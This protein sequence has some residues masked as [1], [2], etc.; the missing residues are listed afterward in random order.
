MDKDLKI[1]FLKNLILKTKIVIVFFVFVFLIQAVA[2][3]ALYKSSFIANIPVSEI[4]IVPAFILFVI[5]DEFFVL[6]FAKQALEGKRKFGEHW[7][8]TLSILEIIYP[9]LVI[10]YGGN[11]FSTGSSEISEFMFLNSPPMM[12]YFLFIILSAFYFNFRISMMTGIL[13]G[14]GYLLATYIFIEPGSAEFAI[15]AT[16]VIFFIGSGIIAGFVGKKLLESVQSSLEAK[17]TLI[18]ELDIK[19]K[20]RTREVESQKELLAEQNEFLNEKNKEI[21]DSITYAKRIQ[22]AILPQDG[23][24]KECLP[25]SFVLYKPKDIVAGDFYWIELIENNSVLFAAADCTGHGVPGAMVSVVCNNALNRAVREFGLREPSLILDK[26][27][28][29]V[30]GEFEK[31]KEDVK[32]GMDIA[33][34][35]LDLQGLEYLGSLIERNDEDSDAPAFTLDRVQ[36]P[37]KGKYAGANNPLWILRNGEITE[38]KPTKRPVGKYDGDLAF[39]NHELEL[40]SGDAIYI[41]SDGFADQ[42]GGEKGKKLK[43]ANFKKLL[44]SIQDKPMNEQKTLIEKAF[45]DWKED[46]EQ[47]DDVCVIGIRI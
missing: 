29:I 37:V 17:N 11:I 32:D 44:I 15:N 36:N 26:V 33:L 10:I 38:I 14:F 3:I 31:S 13:A 12:I 45:E 5:I 2:M 46:L 4:I 22:R 18:N 47:V 30:T 7:K 43:S 41:F 19:V 1:A 21:T 16:K 20:E 40:N 24:F 9:T 25:D 28:E 6:K 27:T 35:K 39:E 8:Y 42:F 23:Y 34:C